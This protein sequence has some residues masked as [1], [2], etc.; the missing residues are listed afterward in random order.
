MC[1]NFVGLNPYKNN[2]QDATVYQNLLFQCLLIAQHLSSDTPPIIKSSKTV[3]TA[4]GFTYVLQTY[5]ITAS[6]FTYVLQT[7]VIPEVVIT[8]FELLMMSGVSLETCWAINKHWNNKFWYTVASCWLF[9]YELYYDVRNHEHQVCWSPPQRRSN[10]PQSVLRT[11]RQCE[12][13]KWQ[14]QQCH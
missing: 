12:L 14:L 3:I 1:I 5:V 9:L 4:S 6:G 13:M 2:Q 7:Y 8:V 11:W 10:F